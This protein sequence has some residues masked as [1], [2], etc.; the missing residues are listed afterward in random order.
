[1]SGGRWQLRRTVS[2]LMVASSIEGV[3]VAVA[4]LREPPASHELLDA[5]SA[6]EATTPVQSRIAFTQHVPGLTPEQLR[7]FA[8]GDRV[9][10][11]SW[12]EAPASVVQFDGLGPFF[13]SRSCSGCHVRDGRGRPP[14]G[15]GD[16]SRAVVTKLAV[17]DA[18]GRWQ[19]DPHYG[20]RLNERA[21]RGL[22]PEARL[23]VHWEE[24]EHV[25]PSGGRTT[26]RRPRFEV[27]GAAYGPLAHGAQL[28]VRIAPAVIG[29]GLLESV[30]DS[31]L[32]ALADSAD[33]D[34][35]GVSGRVHWLDATARE[36]AGATRVPGRFGWKAAQPSLAGQ[37]T[38]ALADDIGITT[39]AK[40]EVE[41]TQAQG[42]A[43]R[44]IQGGQPELEG[45][46][47]DALLDYCRMVAVP[48]RRDLDDT[49]VRRGADRFRGAGCASCH[50]ATLTTG[51]D[52][53][54]AMS[55][56]V[57]H[58]YSD[59]LLHDMGPGLSDG[60]PELGAQAAEWRTAPLWGIGLAASVN[61]FLYLLHDGRARS[62]EEAVLW[63]GGEAQQSRDA[64]RALPASSR[65]DL[66]RFL[67]SL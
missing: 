32:I 29:V 67:E 64:F 28:S 21:V 18:S 42:A 34:G 19:P 13:S 6:G 44:R 17:L 2:V 43:K 31:T 57:I 40:R 20:H 14:E 35:D 25:Y 39:P 12:V 10:R 27:A 52:R 63:H 37:V 26:L 45:A 1:M 61:G 56:Q 23:V 36:A 59:L 49:A 8:L 51:E 47:L 24:V 50:V 4:G 5:R 54:A 41:L 22:V 58:P 9:F 65:S 30:P 7:A 33:T 48:A 3:A 15:P 60:L 62:H 55:R 46:L 53:V 38:A 11:T 16:A 66:I